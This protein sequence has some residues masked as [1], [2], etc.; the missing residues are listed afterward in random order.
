[1]QFD[2]PDGPSVLDKVH[3][4]LAE[5]KNAVASGREV[6]IT[7]EFGDLLFALVSYGRHLGIVAEEALHA[8]IGHFASRF[9]AME[10]LLDQR[11]IPLGVASLEQMDAVW[12]EIKTWERNAQEA[13]SHET[14]QSEDSQQE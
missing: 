13:S 8:G 14:P 2:W 10:E 12:E 9:R 3:E 5:L 6:E 11:G 7:A 4:E 1:V